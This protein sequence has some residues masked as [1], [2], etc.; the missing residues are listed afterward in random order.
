MP[1][2]IASGVGLTARLGAPA[3]PQLPETARKKEAMDRRFQRKV[4]PCVPHH[5]EGLTNVVR[6][7]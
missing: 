1:F 4:V 2:T 3:V 6:G 5:E 7:W